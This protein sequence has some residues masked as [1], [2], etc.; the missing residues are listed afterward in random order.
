M[1]HQR[2]ESADGRPLVGTPRSDQPAASHPMLWTPEVASEANDN[3]KHTTPSLVESF[4]PK[5]TSPATSP[6]AQ[7]V[8]SLSVCG[9][10]D[11]EGGLAGWRTVIGGCV[12][13]ARRSDWHGEKVLI[14][15]IRCRW[16]IMFATLGCASSKNMFRLKIM[17]RL[18]QIF[19]LVRRLPRLVCSSLQTCM[20]CE[21]DKNTDYYTRILLSSHTP[22]A[23]AWIGSVQLML[24]FFFGAVAGK[25]FDAGY[26]HALEFTG[27]IILTIS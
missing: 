21:A 8:E 17:P 26:F 27:A 5:E 25:L 15:I 10:T 6:K 22:S 2:V 19:V 14:V 18:C 24:P 1:S 7:A 20:Q 3:A 11:S 12:Y 23:I 13:F 16:F 9:V 4:N